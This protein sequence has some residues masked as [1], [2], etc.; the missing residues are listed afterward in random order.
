M[1]EQESG[2]PLN[3]RELAEQLS[4]DGYPV[5]QPAISR[6]GDTLTYL[7]PAIPDALY[8]GLGRPQIRKLLGL[9]KVA[10]RTWQR[11]APDAAADF[12]AFFQQSLARCDSDIKQ[13]SVERVR[14]ELL[15]DLAQRL[16]LDYGELA[17]EIGESDLRRDILGHLLEPEVPLPLP[18]PGPS[19]APFTT[20]PDHSAQPTVEQLR[21]RIAELAQ[22]LVD[23]PIEI[24]PLPEHLGFI[25]QCSHQAELTA[26]QQSLMTMLQSLTGQSSDSIR[27]GSLL[28]G[29]DQ[30]EPELD[31]LAFNCLIRLIKLGRQLSH[32][33][34]S[35]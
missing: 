20:R 8:G 5:D 28:C 17:L 7:L 33:G 29:T 12:S 32:S 35:I 9:R 6:M 3:Q 26:L 24:L 10:Q 22:S 27:L 34:G 13:F 1:Y 18:E 23:K 21:K 19:S 2:Q 14:D 15:G 16:T 30:G 31:D 11:H 25:C 4:E